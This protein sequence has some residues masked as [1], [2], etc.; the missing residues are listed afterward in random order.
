M[1]IEL[2]VWLGG[3]QEAASDGRRRLL[4]GGMLGLALKTIT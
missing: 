1:E 4:L 3:Q 2:G